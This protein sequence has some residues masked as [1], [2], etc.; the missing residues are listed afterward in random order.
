MA[1]N[2]ADPAVACIKYII[3]FIN[4]LLWSFG[5]TL[6]GVAIWVRGDG[7]LWEYTDNMD[8]GRYYWATY[9]CLAA[10]ALI[11]IVG[12][13]GCLGA[14][15]ENPCMLMTYF[16]IMVLVI[17]LEITATVLVWK[18]A[19]GDRLQR[20]LSGEMKWHMERRPYDPKSR[21]FLD[22]IQL[23]LECCGAE[24]FL[25]YDNMW[26][27]KPA[28]C[29]NDRTNNINIRSCGE[30]LRRFLEIR[31]GAIGGVCMALLLIEIGAIIFTICL[32]LAM[33]QEE[34]RVLF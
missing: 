19:G 11:L 20:V 24:S 23:K 12:L 25:D 18:I 17:V 34:H 32:F 31:G 21:R 10:G 5:I 9:L 26:Q 8:I 16:A 3:F 4:F 6:I 7:G 27:D 1:T 2:S 13:L 33:R 22:L 28:S 30:M 29:N 14:A 15:T